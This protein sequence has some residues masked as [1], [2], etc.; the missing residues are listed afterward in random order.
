M[1]ARI[2]Y[3]E[4]DETLSF[5]TKDNLELLGYSISH[6]STGAEALRLMQKETFDLCL[7]DV[8]LPDLDG[9]AL[10]QSIRAGN[11]EIPILFL[12]ARTAREDRLTG[13]RLGA[14]DYITKP[15]GIE[16]LVLKIEVFLR[17]RNIV[18]DKAKCTTLTIG[19]LV[20]D[21]DNQILYDGE[22]KTSLTFRECALLSFLAENQEQVV[23]RE[24]ILQK[25][26]GN[27]HFFSS[28]S[29]DV[30]ISRLRSILKADPDLRIESIHNVG[31]RLKGKM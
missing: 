7:L 14:D 28:R 19:R 16:E 5:I 20:I 18:V 1:K 15:F 4:D 25:V 29:L 21:R 11:T 9:F 12:T 27:D 17:R 31:Y 23:K 13:L 6:C 2:L 24:E 22:N 3:V 30:F 10:A 8:M 26:W